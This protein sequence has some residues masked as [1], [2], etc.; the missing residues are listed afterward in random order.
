MNVPFSTEEFLNV[1]KAYNE[2]VFPTQIIIWLICIY[3]VY[4]CYSPVKNTNKII[5]IFLAV[6]WLWMGIAYHILFF[7]KINNAAFLFGAMFI[8]QGILFLYYGYIKGKF[9]F[10]FRKD[11]YGI[12]GLVMIAYALFVYPALGFVTDHIYP[13]SPTIGLPCPTTIFTFGILMFN[14][15]KTPFWLLIIPVIWSLIGTS[16]VI[17]FGVYEDAG[18]LV[19]ALLSTALMLRRNKSLTTSQIVVPG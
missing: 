2:A 4:I 12:T 10:I 14:R 18:L 6:F 9:H 19:A 15:N 13:A 7:S 16:A 11:L 5:T 8:L 1:F 17:N 3:L